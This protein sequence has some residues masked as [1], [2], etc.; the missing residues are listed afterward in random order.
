MFKRN[1]MVL[2]AAILFIGMVFAGGVFAVEKDVVK[3]TTLEKG[4]KDAILEE[5]GAF[6]DKNPAI[7]RSTI[8][9]MA[10][11][12]TRDNKAD[13]AIALY[14]KASKILPSDEEILSRLG[15]MYNQKADYLKAAEIYA[16]LASLKPDNVWYSNMLSE[17]YINAKQNDKAIAVWE[18]LMK[19]S[20]NADV[21][22]QAA[23]FYSRN[24]DMEK[25]IAAIKKAAELK[26]ENSGYLQNLESFYVR[27]EK[28][29]EAEA[30]C[31][32]AITSSKEPWI[33]DWANSKTKEHK[34]K[35]LF[36]SRIIPEKGLSVVCVMPLS[37]PKNMERKN[38]SPSAAKRMF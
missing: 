27:A 28:F 17:A 7:L 9:A 10:D 24:N 32:K 5:L 23:N 12:Y 38:S 16:K 3:S 11:A 13:S 14:E 22:Q 33:K 25:A 31:A 36:K 8:F 15:G 4:D 21:F 37:T 26:P 30:V 1:Y 35:S 20:S 19:K 29:S 2:T 34:A 6:V 18:D